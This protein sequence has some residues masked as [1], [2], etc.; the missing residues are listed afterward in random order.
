[1]DV[2]SD[3]GIFRNADALN[4]DVI[5]RFSTLIDKALEVATYEAIIPKITQPFTPDGLRVMMHTVS[6]LI[7]YEKTEG[8]E[9]PAQRPE[10]EQSINEQLKRWEV[11]VEI[12][13]E[14]K[15][16]AK[17]T[18]TD[19]L[20]AGMPGSDARQADAV[21]SAFAKA[22][23]AEGLNTLFGALVPVAATAA[24]ALT[25]DANIEADL[26]GM[27]GRCELEGFVPDTVLLPRGA[28]SRIRRMQWVV[29]T[30][31]S[32][33]AYLKE[34]Y[35]LDAVKVMPISYK[36]GTGVNYNLFTPFN[37][38]L[39]FRKKSFGT[40]SQLMTEAEAFRDTPRG[41]D[42]AMVRKFW[43]TVAAQPESAQLLNGTGL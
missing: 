22:I 26:D 36:Y 20:N 35:G 7:A 28:L 2:R 40:F 16:T 25:A 12:T 9:T 13:D 21:G 23:D 33:E 37:Q 3:W 15:I 24:W 18:A 43:L 31:K 27:I 29:N 14:A 38:V 6:D 39:M 5:E 17:Y 30:S 4:K 32:P 34:N 11:K 8:A 41:V 19:L 1:M 10:W 42:A